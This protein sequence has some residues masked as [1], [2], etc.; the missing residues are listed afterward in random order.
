MAISAAYPKQGQ[1][2][3]PTLLELTLG[4]LRIPRDVCRLTGLGRTQT[5]ADLDRYVWEELST[6]A[7]RTLAGEVLRTVRRR[8][9]DVIAALAENED[10]LFP[11]G[12]RLGDLEISTRASNALR[13]TGLVIDDDVSGIPVGALA[14]LPSLGALTLLQILS[15]ADAMNTDHGP[16][17][18]RPSATPSTPIPHELDPRLKRSAGKLVKRRWSHKVHDDDPRLGGAVGRLDRG[19]R[20]SKSGT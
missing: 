5:F 14:R 4:Q 7:V 20:W 19:A 12:T 16:K 2:L 17:S 11:A 1:P 6:A 13:N 8:Q 3:L 9:F 10:P 15:A 18:R